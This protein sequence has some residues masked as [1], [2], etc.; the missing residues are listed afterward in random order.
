MPR[1]ARGGLGGMSRLQ[2]T[3]LNRVNGSRP[4]WFPRLHQ[5]SELAALAWPLARLAGLL[6]VIRCRDEAG[7]ANSARRHGPR[8]LRL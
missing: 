2:V 3:I 6:F 1:T 8:R 4:W 5:M 7:S